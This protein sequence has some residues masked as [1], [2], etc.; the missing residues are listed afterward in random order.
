MNYENTLILFSLVS[1]LLGRKL[2]IQERRLEELKSKGKPVGIVF[3]Q[4]IAALCAE[5]V[6]LTIFT[7][8]VYGLLDLS[9]FLAWTLPLLAKT[10]II[11]FFLCLQ[12][13]AHALELKAQYED[14]MTASCY[15]LLINLSCRHDNPEEALSLKREL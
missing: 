8:T 13:L 2:A 9:P 3:R 15:A 10:C 11:L 5:E 1:Q 6:R 12:N 14:E 7:R 4:L